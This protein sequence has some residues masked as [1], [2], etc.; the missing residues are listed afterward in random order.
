MRVA[1]I[2]GTAR[3]QGNTHQ[4]ATYLRDGVAGTLFNLADYKIGTYDY[5]HLNIND[6]FLPLMKEILMFDHIM[7][8]SPIYWY[9]ASSEMKVFLD[10]LSDLMTIEKN[11]GRQLR[12]KSAS[13]L[14]TGCDI[15][16]PVCFEQMFELTYR[17]LGINY[18][19]MLYCPCVDHL[20]IEQHQFVINSFLKNLHA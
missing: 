5:E 6:D 1:I 16:P 8:A 18:R 11:L 12:S 3:N 14:A 7:L 20:E 19:G 2:L 10:R 9:A 15:E 4:L 13:L 17:H